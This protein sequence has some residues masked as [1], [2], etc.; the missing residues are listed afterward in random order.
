[1]GLASVGQAER[2]VGDFASP[3][4]APGNLIPKLF[5]LLALRKAFSGLPQR[6]FVGQFP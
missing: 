1:V 2:P 5:P 3:A 4:S 6:G